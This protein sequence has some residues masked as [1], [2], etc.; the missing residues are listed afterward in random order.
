MDREKDGVRCS[1]LKERDRANAGEQRMDGS[2]FL[3]EQG[4]TLVPEFRERSWSSLRR[5]RIWGLFPRPF[6]L[7]VGVLLFPQSVIFSLC[8]YDT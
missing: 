3:V 2:F 5:D 7:M 6:A 1:R 8:R 4:E